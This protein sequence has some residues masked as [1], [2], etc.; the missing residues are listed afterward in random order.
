MTTAPLASTTRRLHRPLLATTAGMTVLAVVSLCA[1][2]FDD[3]ML[4]NES[5]WLK[6]LKFAFAFALYTGTLAWLLSFPHRGQRLTWWMGTAFAVTATADVGFIAV[7][8]ARGTFSHFNNYDTDTVNVIGQHV[9]QYG[10]PGLFLANLV[11]ALMLSWQKITDLPTTRAIHYGLGIAVVG[12]ALAYFMGYGGKQEVTDAYGKPVTLISGHTIINGQPVV[13]DGLGE[14]PVSHWSTVGGDMR[15]PHFVGLHGIQILIL[16]ALVLARLAPQVPW[17]RS[18]RARADLIRVLAVG[19]AGL[20][21]TLLWQALRGQPVTHPDGKTLAALGAVVAVTAAGLGLVYAVR[22]RTADTSP[23]VL[24]APASMFDVTEPLP[25]LS[26][27][28]Q[29]PV[30][31]PPARR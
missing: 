31:A 20:L 29:R 8:A 18:E 24:E 5:V 21:G 7:Q 11:I 23:T 3:R 17:L 6:S 30:S 2:A 22:G 26:A 28:A 13:R 14:M 4:L 15:I 12:M 19:Y 25:A 16:A 9:F 1:M 10:V 27:G